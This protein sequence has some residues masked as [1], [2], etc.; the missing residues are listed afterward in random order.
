MSNDSNEYN[1]EQ[2]KDPLMHT[3]KKW[4]E[5]QKHEKEKEWNIL[6][7]LEKENARKNP[8][9]T[10]VPVVGLGSFHISAFKVLPSRE[11]SDHDLCLWF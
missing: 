2:E 5:G 4:R 8:L 10:E 1:S 9:V 3:N 11:N 7:R 6:S